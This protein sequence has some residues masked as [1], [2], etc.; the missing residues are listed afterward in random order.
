MIWN[1]EQ[2]PH[3]SNEG[4]TCK[5]YKNGD[6][7]KYN[8][9]RRITLLNI[10]YKI[11]NISLNKRLIENMENKQED[12]Q[13][14][15]LPNRFTIDNNFIEKQILRKAMSIIL[16]CKIYSWIIHKLMTLSIEIR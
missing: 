4:I 10:A 13:T 1:N 14:G 3:Q 9:Y 16:I 6:K 8:N 12:N 7:L 15:F 11:L 2:L 5:Y